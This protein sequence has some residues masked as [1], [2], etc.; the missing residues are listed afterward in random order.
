M[1]RRSVLSTIFGGALGSLL[2]GASD[3]AEAA[4]KEDA[5]PPGTTVELH[6]KNAPFPTKDS[7]WKDDTVIA[8]VPEHFVFPSSGNVDVIMHFHGHKTNA[9]RSIR[10]NMLREQLIKSKQ[11]AILVVPQGP[12]FASSG[13][14]GKLMNKGGTAKLLKEVLSLL[15]KQKVFD[16]KAKLGR[17]IVSASSGGYRPTAMTIK[18]GGVDLREVYLFDALY[19]E[20]AI[21]EG[22]VAKKKKK[23]ISYYVGGEPMTNSLAIA[24]SLKDKGIA[25][26]VEEGETRLTREDLVKG[27]AIFLRGRASHGTATFEEGA[28]RDC[29][30]A[31]C[32]KGI[33]TKEWHKNKKKE[34][35]KH[36]ALD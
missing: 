17:V 22:L 2:F 36:L 14:F 7:E 25:V 32:F 19:G 6:P 9:W 31:S 35:S 34:R 16:E 23:L 30:L 8:Y 24:G 28:L 27:K 29:L 10:G 4:V 33:G 20:T 26:R 18:H 12:V 15:H 1:L 13:D 21:F 3:V 5:P 11:N